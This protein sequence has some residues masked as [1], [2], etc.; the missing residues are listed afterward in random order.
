[1]LKF[2]KKRYKMNLTTINECVFKP[3][4]YFNNKSN[5]VLYIA[6]IKLFYKTSNNTNTLSIDIDALLDDLNI[7]DKDKDIFPLSE[8]LYSLA[9]RQI[10]LKYTKRAKDTKLG[11]CVISYFKINNNSITIEIIDNIKHAI[12]LLSEKDITQLDT[13]SL[14]KSSY[15]SLIYNYILNED[16]ENYWT[17]SLLELRCFVNLKEGKYKQFSDFKTVILDTAKEEINILT[18]YNMD[19][20]R[21]KKTNMITISW[22]ISS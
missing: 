19:Y 22:D 11:F 2:G 4:I 6:I 16:K 12:S 14:F 9:R 15:T 21:V 13:Y 17:L 3:L 1:M 7:S 5:S 8:T 18:P 10:S 20:K